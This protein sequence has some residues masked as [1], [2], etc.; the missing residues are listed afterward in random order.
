MRFTV[1]ARA[2]WGSAFGGG[3][4]DE[5][6][7]GIEDPIG[8]PPQPRIAVGGDNDRRPAEV[9]QAL[10]AYLSECR[11]RD[12]R[13]QAFLTGRAPR[14]PLPPEPCNGAVRRACRRAGLEPAGAHRPRH[15]LAHGL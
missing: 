12:D 8:T 13:R 6:A 10:S 5:R 11:P 2:T 7:A 14:R 15:A 9:G 4:R 1:P 3:V